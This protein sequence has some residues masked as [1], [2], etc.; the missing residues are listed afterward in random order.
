MSYRIWSFYNTLVYGF[1]DFQNG[2]GIWKFDN[3]LLQ[4]EQYLASIILQILFQMLKQHMQFKIITLTIYKIS[5]M[6]TFSPF[7]WSTVIRNVAS[8][9]KSFSCFIFS[10]ILHMHVSFTVSWY[11]I[12]YNFNSMLWDS[13]PMLWD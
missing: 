1:I 4:V 12:K 5:L 13:Y 6:Q 10:H 2:K 8:R 3:S 9:Y 11:P 7:I